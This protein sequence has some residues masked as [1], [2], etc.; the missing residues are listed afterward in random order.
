MLLK[1]AQK[2]RAS[3]L[4]DLLNTM[5][6]HISKID[7]RK[8]RGKYHEIIF[9]YRP[10]L[11]IL[12]FARPIL[13]S[14][15]PIFYHPIYQRFLVLLL[16]ALLTTGRR[17]VSNLLRTAA[18]LGLVEVLWV[19]V[20]DLSGTHRDSY[21]FS[22]DPAMLVARVIETYT[23]R[24]DIEMSHPDHPSSDSLYRRSRAA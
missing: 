18:G 7:F 10:M 16:A 6:R 5:G 17:T 22:T 23:G 19:F 15:A 14:F 9:D 2:L 12:E 8:P 1:L 21:L 24:W 11:V 13:S 20:H 4:N 3:R